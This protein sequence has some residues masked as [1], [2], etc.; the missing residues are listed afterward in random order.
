MWLPPITPMTVDDLDAIMALERVCF[1]DPWTRRMYLTD[2]TE[3]ALATYLVVRPP[4]FPRPA[5]PQGSEPAPL[6]SI[7]AYGGFWLMVDEAHIATIA[8]HPD[9]RGCGLGLYLMLGLLDAARARGARISTLEVRAS[10]TAAQNLYLK[11]G[12]ELVGRRRRY[13][14]DGEDAL[15]MTTPPLADPLMQERLAGA[16]RA[17]L[18]R[19]ERCLEHV[20]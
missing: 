7:L 3:N 14:R 20:P 11:L 4:S 2:L 16:R 5:P 19:I 6:P 12:Y 1:K 15:L 18:A 10:N 8:T 9:W 13:Y 17:A